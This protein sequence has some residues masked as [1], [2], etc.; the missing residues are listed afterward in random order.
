M[1]AK[2]P[3]GSPSAPVAGNRS[4]L[5]TSAC[6]AGT[7]YIKHHNEIKTIFRKIEKKPVAICI[8]NGRN[9]KRR[10]S[11]VLIYRKKHY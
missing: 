6:S 8:K 7:C 10:G 1:S 11:I 3:K 4:L 2:A 5:G 9:S